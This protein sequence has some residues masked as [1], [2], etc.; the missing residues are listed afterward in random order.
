MNL[1]THRG[2][3]NNHP[4]DSLVLHACIDF[5]K[6]HFRCICAKQKSTC[7]VPNND[8]TRRLSEKDVSSIAQ[9]HLLN[10]RF[11]FASHQLAPLLSELEQRAAS[12]PDP[13]AS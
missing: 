1:S 7:S 2:G 4:G 12:H 9:H 5:L 13:P 8:I 11:Q 10:T 6:C 3:L